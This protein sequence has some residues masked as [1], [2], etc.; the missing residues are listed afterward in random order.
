METT[1]TTC[2]FRRIK[3]GKIERGIM[4]GEGEIIIDKNF[5]PVPAPIWSYTPLPYEGLLPIKL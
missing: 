4:I 1:V 3:R 5:K 2:I